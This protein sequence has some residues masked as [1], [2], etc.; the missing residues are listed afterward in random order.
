MDDK[1]DEALNMILDQVKEKLNA[2]PGVV[3]LKEL[4]C[5]LD[6]VVWTKRN[7]KEKKDD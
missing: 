4:G 6:Q 2:H 3:D 5:I 1:I 7:N